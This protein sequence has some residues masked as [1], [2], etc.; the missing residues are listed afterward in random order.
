MLNIG[1]EKVPL[2]DGVSRRS[3]LQLGTAG[4]AAMSLPTLFQLEAN[5]SIKE[6]PAQIKNCITIFLVGSPGQHDTWDMKPDAPAEIR[7]K[8]KPIQT[9]VNGVRICEHFPLMAKMMD[10]VALIRSLHH[11]TGATHENGQRWMMTGHDFNAD[12]I[13]PH[14]GSIVSRV[15][16]SRGDLPANVILPGPIGNTGAGPLH[17]QTAGYLGS[18]HEPFFLNSDPARPE[19]K[20]ADLEVPAGESATRLDARTRLLN[21]VDELQR[22]TETKSTQ[23]HDASYERAFRLLTSSS[24]KRAFNLSEE[25]DT[26]RDRYGRNTFGQ[27]CLMARRLVENGVRYVTVNHFD[28]VFG[29]SCWDMHADGGGLNN[30]YL[31]YERHLCPQFDWAFTALITDLEQRGLLKE[32]V[33]AVL[34][35]FGRTPQ[36][37]GRGGRDHYPAAWTNFLCGGNIRGG[38]VVG[39][40]DKTGARPNDSPVEPPQII[41]SIYQGMGIDLDATTMPGPG[42]R[43]V[44]L[45]DAEPIRQLFA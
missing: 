14:V 36:V 34:S 4:M 5:G 21:Q 22:R 19:F 41:A 7:G 16:G 11:K 8:F 44:R 30:T 29:Q 40:T 42:D 33:V 43:P 28:T 27:S 1:N 24:A 45:V 35:E 18:G 10:K 31:D 39:S 3:F 32:T 38:Q 25:K 37:N 2:C 12:S 23:M 20:V 26:L 15:F 9:N 17:G 13:K 6:K